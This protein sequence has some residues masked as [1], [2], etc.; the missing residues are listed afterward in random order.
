MEGS[1]SPADK[2]RPDKASIDPTCNPFS[3][4]FH[5]QDILFPQMTGHRKSA[6][7]FLQRGRCCI[8]KR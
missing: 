4:E 2:R 3:G 6:I 1:Q 7:P 8:T 5:H